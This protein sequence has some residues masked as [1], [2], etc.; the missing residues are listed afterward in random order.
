[1]S[2]GKTTF[3]GVEKGICLYVYPTWCFGFI[4]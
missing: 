2:E 1:M 3:F 4:L